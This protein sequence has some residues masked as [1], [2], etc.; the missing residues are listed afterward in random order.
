MTISATEGLKAVIEDAK[1][2]DPAQPLPPNLSKAFVEKLNI[3]D[4][5]EWD[6]Y[7][8]QKVFRDMEKA[9]KEHLTLEEF[10]A[11]LEVC[12]DFGFKL[13]DDVSPDIV[14]EAMDEE[15]QGKISWKELIE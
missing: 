4:V 9:D 5:G 8:I 12:K 6:L 1:R 15:K 10:K 2:D 3:T 13:K 11:G 14:F 7:V